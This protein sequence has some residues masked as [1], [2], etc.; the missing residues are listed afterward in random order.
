MIVR[1]LIGLIALLGMSTA[2]VSAQA[3]DPAQETAQESAEESTE[4]SGPIELGGKIILDLSSMASGGSDQRLRALTNIDLTAEADLAALIGWHGAKAHVHILDNRGARPNDAIGTLQGINNIEVTKAGLR[5]FKAFVEQELG[6]GSTL[7]VGLYD[8]NS[9]F[10]TNAAASLLIAPAFGIGSELAS[11]GPNGPSI[12]PS[13]ALAARL[14]VPVLDGKS[15]VQFA[16]INARAST[17][18]DDGGVDFSFRDGV[19]LIGEAGLVS[20]PVRGSLGSWLYAR[21]REALNEFDAQGLPLRKTAA[22]AYVVVEADI[23]P[24]LT[25]FLRAGISDDHSSPF[26][27]GLQTGVMLTPVIGGRD[28]SALSLGLNH[29]WLTGPARGALLASGTDPARGETALELTFADEV[30]EGVTLQPDVQ[31]IWHAGGIRTARDAI[32][33]TLR[34]SFE[35]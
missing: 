16:V 27:G 31:W 15:Y 28:K 8:L 25:G 32:A 26:R 22:G 18:G 30:I 24:T 6:G 12:F 5:L 29:A 14:R 21:K 19:L 2:Q 33:T 11:T 34:M 1:R 23:L 20:G 4:G 13:S 7:L 17:M 3:Q 35:F 9:E 10:Y